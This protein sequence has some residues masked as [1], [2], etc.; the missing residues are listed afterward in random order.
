VL[1]SLSWKYTVYTRICKKKRHCFD[2]C[3]FLKKHT[4]LICFFHMANQLSSSHQVIAVSNESLAVIAF[5][6]WQWQ[7]SSGCLVNIVFVGSWRWVDRR[8]LCD[9]SWHGKHNKQSHFFA[10]TLYI[11]C[12][13]CLSL[14]LVFV[15]DRHY[16]MFRRM[17]HISILNSPNWKSCSCS[18][19]NEVSSRQLW[20]VPYIM[21][22]AQ[23]HT[24]HVSLIIQQY[25]ASHIGISSWWSTIVV[26]SVS[27]LVN[28]DHIYS[29]ARCVS[30]LPINEMFLQMHKR[31][32]FFH[33]EMRDPFDI[34]SL[35]NATKYIFQ[36]IRS[37]RPMLAFRGITRCLDSINNI[38]IQKQS[39]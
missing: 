25:T 10:T 5:G 13:S 2:R 23:H 14:C 21:I 26:V 30:L 15:P 29:T 16:Q 6:S 31:W 24:V 11:L 27:Q 18:S 38:W 36:E 34:D 33:P 19:Q 3:N 20:F 35:H 28:M 32:Y 9:S 12:F 37:T 39:P 8:W 4:E 1:Y 7:L 22:T 17:C